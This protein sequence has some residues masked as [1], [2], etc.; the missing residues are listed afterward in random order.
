MYLP[1]QLHLSWLVQ[2][3]CQCRVEDSV[4]ISVD[5]LGSS[6]MF[7]KEIFLKLGSEIS[8]FSKSRERWV[9][10]TGVLDTILW[11]DI[12]VKFKLYSY[13]WSPS[14]YEYLIPVGCVGLL[15]WPVLIRSA[16]NATWRCH[17]MKSFSSLLALCEG[18]P[19]VTGG[20]PSQRASNTQL[21]Y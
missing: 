13:P 4:V 17:D 12:Y 10:K 3:F 21:W 7:I 9:H 6:D 2:I 16:H 18:N 20:F 14:F 15:I 8:L 19:P 5:Y 1:Y 11:C